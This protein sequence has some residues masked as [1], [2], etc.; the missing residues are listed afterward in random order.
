MSALINTL[1]PR[2]KQVFALAARE[3]RARG[4]RSI[5]AHHLL[6]AICYLGQGAAVELLI[7]RGGLNL[8][9]V[10]N[11]LKDSFTIRKAH[12]RMVPYSPRLKI[13]L[14]SAHRIARRM[15]HPH[16]GTEH[17]LLAL[18]K[19]GGRASITLK[20]FGLTGRRF[21]KHLLESH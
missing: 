8:Q 4:H 7:H 1:T 9:D 12:E 10:I 17:L 13:V 14:C 6:F 16:V 5:G 2:A 20:G 11:R 19:N 21:R 3:A 18:L 15:F